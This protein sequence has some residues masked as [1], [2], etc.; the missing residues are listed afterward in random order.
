MEQKLRIPLEDIREE[1]IETVRRVR[2]LRGKDNLNEVIVLFSDIETRD[3]ITSYAR[4]LASFV[5]L[6][7]KPTA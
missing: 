4:N 6:S 1:D 5:D 2:L 3:R 7:G